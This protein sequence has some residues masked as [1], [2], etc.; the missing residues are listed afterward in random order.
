V[1]LHP[2]RQS[3]EVT[4]PVKFITTVSGV[5]KENFRYQWRHN[6]EDINGET[7]NTLTINRVTKDD[8]G[9]YECV[10]NNEYGDYATSNTSELSK[11]KYI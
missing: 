9:N 10:V 8:G 2:A 6:G 1:T 3:V 11:L 5:G 7:S 4:Q